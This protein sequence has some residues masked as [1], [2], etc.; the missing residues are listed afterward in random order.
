MSEAAQ[1]TDI[2]KF[3]DMYAANMDFRR[4]EYRVS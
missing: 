1:T 2:Y 3:G 4:Q